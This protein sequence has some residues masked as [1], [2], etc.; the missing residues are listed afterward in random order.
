MLVK[1]KVFLDFNFEDKDKVHVGL[2]TEFSEILW[3]YPTASSSDIDAYVAYNYLEKVWY[4]GTLARDAWLDRGIRELPIATGSSLLYN[5]EKGFDDDGSAMT[6]FIESA[7]M[8]IGDGD[9]FVSIKQLIPDITF[10]GSTSVN[11]AVS[12][13][14][15]AKTHAGAN[16]GQ[17]GS[18]TAQRSATTPVEQFT[19][20][21]DYRI[22]GRS[23]AIRV[24]STDLG[25]KFK[26]GTPRVDIREDGR[27]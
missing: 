10:D 17:S 25:S 11:P 18:E 19:N 2:N 22:R 4:Y 9:K 21:L 12:F 1:D 13:T 23:F 7:P 6:S 26:L 5:H 20:K 24:E 14:I 15:K 27:R 3:F 8:D 16:F